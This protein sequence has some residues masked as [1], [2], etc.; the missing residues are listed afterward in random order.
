MLFKSFPYFL[1]LSSGV[2]NKLLEFF[3]VSTDKFLLNTEVVLNVEVKLLINHIQADSLFSKGL[4][5]FHG[6]V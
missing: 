5:F 4:G 3:E 1:M 6:L 2:L